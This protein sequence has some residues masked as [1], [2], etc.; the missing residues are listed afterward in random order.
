MNQQFRVYY[1]P[2]HCEHTVII[3]YYHPIINPENQPVAL[4]T[5]YKNRKKIDRYDLHVQ[6]IVKIVVLLKKKSF[7]KW[8]SQSLFTEW[9]LHEICAIKMRCIVP[10]LFAVRQILKFCVS[11][12]ISMYITL[13]PILHNFLSIWC[14]F[15]FA[16]TNV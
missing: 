14:I 7:V 4:K 1:I 3:R 5:S 16:K 13:C 2:N 15:G 6:I 9:N 11:S 12:D 10:Y 8:A